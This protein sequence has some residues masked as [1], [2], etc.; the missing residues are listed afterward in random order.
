MKDTSTACKKKKDG[1]CKYKGRE[2]ADD[3]G[4]EQM[5]SG[6]EKDGKTKGGRQPVGVI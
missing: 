1:K 4:K 3:R 2:E 6:P 5:D